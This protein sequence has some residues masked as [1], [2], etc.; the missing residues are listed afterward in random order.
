MRI[1]RRKREADAEPPR[2]VRLRLDDGTV[3]GC[4]VIRDPGL[5]C[6]GCAG[7]VAVPMGPLPRSARNGCIEMDVLPPKTTVELRLTIAV[8]DGE[9]P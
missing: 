5:D 9:A 8:P 4:G 6:D 2:G 7:W 3:I 1:L